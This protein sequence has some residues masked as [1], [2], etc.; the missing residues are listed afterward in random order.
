MTQPKSALIQY[1]TRCLQDDVAALLDNPYSIAKTAELRSYWIPLYKKV[2]IQCGLN[3]QRLI[4]KGSPY[5]QERLRLIEAGLPADHKNL[6]A[7]TR[8]KPA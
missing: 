1:A 5:E 6:C 8:E 2:A 7:F 3:W 4:S